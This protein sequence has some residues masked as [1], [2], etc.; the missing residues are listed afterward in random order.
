MD[1]KRLAENVM[2]IAQEVPLKVPRK[3]ANI[4]SIAIKTTESTSLPIYNKTPQELQEI[5]KMA[6]LSDKPSEA[7]TEKRKRKNEAAQK[8]FK[9]RKAKSPLVRALKRQKQ[10]EDDSNKSTAAQTETKVDAGK[11]VAKDEKKNVLDEAKE[12]EQDTDKGNVQ[13]QSPEKKRKV[14]P[15]DA[16]GSNNKGAKKNKQK[17]A[18][19]DYEEVANKSTDE[20]EESSSSVKGKDQ[21]KPADTKKTTPVRDEQTSKA[22]PKGKKAEKKVTP[23]ESST[24][25]TTKPLAED[26]K[27]SSRKSKPNEGKAA[28]F[29]RAKKYSG[30]KVGYVFRKGQQGLGYYEDVKP[31]VDQMMIDAMLRSAN[32]NRGSGKHKKGKKKRGKR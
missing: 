23:R 14:L 24:K 12:E 15:V 32:S 20:L 21:S 25:Q 11:E 22:E 5:A 8:E 31:V 17:K 7:V 28:P 3:W 2:A 6:G 30:S 1:P 27:L 10:M 18:T 4:R 13:S 26:E 16:K 19:P 9:E 29:I